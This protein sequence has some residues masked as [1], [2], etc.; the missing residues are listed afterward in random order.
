[1]FFCAASWLPQFQFAGLSPCVSCR[2]AVISAGKKQ[3]VSPPHPAVLERYR[4]AGAAIFRTD[5]DGAVS[6]DSD[7]SLFPSLPGSKNGPGL[8]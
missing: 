7:D 2:Y 5:R 4:S 6:I 8:R 1:M 3:C